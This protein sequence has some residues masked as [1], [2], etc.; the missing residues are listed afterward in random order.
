MAGSKGAADGA[1]RSWWLA[2]RRSV[3]M[4]GGGVKR[5]SYIHHD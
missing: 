2:V 3:R 5:S 4:A 1:G